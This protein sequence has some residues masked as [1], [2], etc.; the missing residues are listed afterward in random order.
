MN[1]SSNKL[2][3]ESEPLQF[4]LYSIDSVPSIWGWVV[5]I[6]NPDRSCGSGLY[7]PFLFFF[8][9]VYTP[10]LFLDFSNHVPNFF[11]QKILFVE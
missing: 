2:G 8:A 5:L 3:S 7:K 10:A 1:P 4:L 6:L 11:C 9:I